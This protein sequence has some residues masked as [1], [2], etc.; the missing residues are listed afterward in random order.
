MYSSPRGK[1]NRLKSRSQKRIRYV[2]IDLPL[3]GTPTWHFHTELYKFQ[4]NVSANNS[5]TE[6]RTDLRRGEAVC[7]Y[8]FYNIT[9]S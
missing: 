9:N 2:F 5:T 6:Y 4:S 3:C 1:S 7:L 8:I